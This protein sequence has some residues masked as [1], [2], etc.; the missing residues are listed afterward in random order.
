MMSFYYDWG[1]CQWDTTQSYSYGDQ[2]FDCFS[3]STYSCSTSNYYGDNCVTLDSYSSD[4]VLHTE[5][6][7]EVSNVSFNLYGVNI[8]DCGDGN[9]CDVTFKDVDGNDVQPTYTWVDGHVKV[10]CDQPIA[11]IDIVNSSYCNFSFKVGSIYCDPQPTGDGI[12]S[13][14][15]GEDLIDYDYLGDPDGDQVDHNDALIAG[16]TGNDDIIDAGDGNDVVLAGDG[17]DEV[18]GGTGD[19]NLSGNGG[20]DV[21]YGDSEL[22]TVPAASGENLIVNGSF[23]DTTGMSQISYGYTAYGSISGWTSDTPYD[24]YAEPDIDI[25]S[26]ERGGLVATDGNY[27]LDLA[28]TPGN[29]S[30][31]QDVQG[32]TNGVEYTLSFDAGDIAGGN[33]GFEVYWGGQLI[34][35]IDPTDG[36]MSSY[37]Y[38]VTGGAGD[39]SDRLQFVGTGP[40]DNFGASIDN[41]Q[42]VGTIVPDAAGNDTIDG[43]DGDDILYGEDGE[44][45]LIGGAGDDSMFGGAGNDII[46]DVSST[47]NDGAGN[48]YADGGAGD[49]GIWTG[50]GD[51]TLVG[52]SGDDFLNGEAGN[53]VIYGGADSDYI[54]ADGGDYVDGGSEGNDDDTLDLSGRGPFYLTNV[55]PDLNG[56]GTNGTVVFVD[57]Y[58]TPT[59]ETIEY[60]EIENIIGDKVNMT[61]DAVNDTATTD[62]D[63]PVTIDV[64]AN[65]SDPDGDPLTVV[66][67]S[68]PDGD[69]TI[70]PDGTLTFT[71]NPDFNGDATITY[72]V[73]DPSGLQDTASVDVTVNPVND[74]P[75]AV[76]D[77][78]TTDFNTPVTVAVLA[79]DSDPEGDPLSVVS[80]SSPDGTVVINPDN[81]ITFT[82]YDG[83]EGQASVSYTIQDPDGLTDTAEVVICVNDDPRDGTVEGTM[84]D[85]LIDVNYTGDPDGDMVDANDAILPGDTGNDDLI[86]GFGGDDTIISGDGNDEVYGDEGNDT[87]T[88]T[89]GSDTVYGGDGNDVID[90]SNGSDPLPDLA[91]PGLWAADADPND[92]KD[93]VDGGTGDDVISTGDD[94]D[95]I[96]GGT[97][98]DTIDGGI[99][100]DTIDGGEGNDVIIGGEGSDIIDGGA[101]DDLIYGGLDDSFPDTINIPDADGDLVTNNGKD[102]IDAGAGN[103]TVYGADDDDTILGGTGDDYLDGGVDDDLIFG[104]DGQDTIIGGEG[105]DNLSGGY[106]SDTFLGGNAGDVVVGGE[107]ADGNDWDVLDLNGSNVDFVTYTSADRED[108][109]VT[110]NDGS[111]MT[112]SEIE[113]VIPCFTPGTMIATARGE[114]PVENLK[115]GDKVITRDNGIQEIAWVGHKEMSGKQLIANPHLKPV[116]VKAGSLGHGLP[117]RDMMVSPNHRLLVASDLTQLYFEEREV[118]A[119]AKHLVG[120]AGIHQVDV[121]ATTYI[122]FMFERHEV[123]LS[124]GS[125][126]ESFQPGDY[127]LKGIGNSQRNE[128]FE[129]FP[130]LKEKAGLAGYQSARKSLKKHE[131]RLLVR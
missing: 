131:A 19:D 57:A 98:N 95:S 55:T 111:T 6:D 68:S 128:I 34:D 22:G 130:E 47:S 105:T 99:D 8:W 63:T 96:I 53:D 110:F 80:A 75:D 73:E 116:L 119:A 58:G 1:S 29:L 24:P 27:W 18:Y 62:E 100:A 122:H 46:D 13:G 45:R 78:A 125:W 12:V 102:V 91:Y 115:E 87:I 69:V 90:T 85:D 76:D 44:D 52:G 33:N 81:T 83:F 104:G 101:G 65:D 32:V 20:N 54:R 35:T 38:T 15:A 120:S 56:N 16:E 103:D 112:F 36:Y 66:S 59:G 48:D 124:N 28:G 106:G 74:A 64:L 40:V 114:V 39:G 30:I 126:T 51:D 123:V 113:N 60:V 42:L 17:N 84:G 41:V 117:E 7:C 79:N 109:I 86:H 21:I 97:G 14:S 37:S 88:D 71:P 89:E 67:A 127:S 5:F 92:D 31:G 43:G 118:L 77:I 93:F 108:G 129:L 23:E 70:N 121:M 11:S 94:A 61:P 107:D 9:L 4:N 72:T 26:D 10:T 82:P 49:D 25:H 50:E 2:S 3:S